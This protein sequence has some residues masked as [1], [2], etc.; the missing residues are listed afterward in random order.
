MDPFRGDSDCRHCGGHCS[1]GVPGPLRRRFTAC[2]LPIGKTNVSLQSGPRS[3]YG[4][5]ISD[6]I[7]YYG[8]WT[9]LRHSPAPPLDPV[10]IEAMG[11]EPILHPV[12]G[13]LLHLRRI[14]VEKHRPLR[15]H[16]RLRHVHQRVV[17]EIEVEG[18]ADN[19]RGRDRSLGGPLDRRRWRPP[20]SSASSLR[21]RWCCCNLA[22]VYPGPQRSLGISQ[23]KI[24]LSR[25]HYDSLPIRWRQ[26]AAFIR[27]G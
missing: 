12:P 6:T 2:C 5:V 3:L 24:I 27:R 20:P 26:Y 7:S 1:H 8:R 13:Q 16:I 11:V 9:I 21:S 23:V 17:L 22:R 14:Q 25:R 15:R 10:P 4:P 19:G 18:C